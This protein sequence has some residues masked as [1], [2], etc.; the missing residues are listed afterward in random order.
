[1]KPIHKFNNGRGAT[2]CNRCRVIINTGFSEAL[3]CDKC[4][5]IEE[6]GLNT[7]FEDDLL[8]GANDL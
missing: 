3:Y 1:M 5:E 7:Y 6:L 8:P 2:L 4:L